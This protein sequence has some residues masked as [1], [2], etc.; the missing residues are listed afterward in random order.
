[1]LQYIRFSQPSGCCPL[2]KYVYRILKHII[3][4]HF[5]RI[6]IHSALELELMFSATVTVNL[7]ALKGIKLELL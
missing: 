5:H 4:N 7:T 2:L 1:M 6:K 3:D